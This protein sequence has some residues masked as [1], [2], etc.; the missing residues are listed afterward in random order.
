[1]KHGVVVVLSLVLLSCRA[2]WTVRPIQD[3][4]AASGNGQPFDAALFVRSVWESKVVPAAGQAGDFTAW[5]Q[6][7]AASGRP[8]LVKG[9]GRVLRVDP[10]RQLLLL[11]VAPFDGKPDV[12]LCFGQIQGTAL[13]DALRFVQ[14]SHFLNQVDYARA[15]NALNEQAAKVASAALAGSGPVGSL[16]SFAGAASQFLGDRLPEIVPVIVTR[17]PAQP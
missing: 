16:L 14:F 5:R 7:A 12:A 1:M 8:L 10:A 17:E 9:R 4:E 3:A 13:R 15:S 11:D 2:P 6:S